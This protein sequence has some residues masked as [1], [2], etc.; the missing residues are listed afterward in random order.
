MRAG[1]ALVVAAWASGGVIENVL[2]ALSQ[3][4][5]SRAIAELRTYS[6]SHGATPELLEAMSWLARAEL[7]SRNYAA[8]QAYSQQTYDLCMAR[9]CRLPWA[10]P[11]RSRP[12]SW[13][14]KAAVARP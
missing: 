13:P 4:S 3:G 1:L 11:S 10:R 2:A 12:A 5:E 6:A 8:A 7:E 14:H 9:I